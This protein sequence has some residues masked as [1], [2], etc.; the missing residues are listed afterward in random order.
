M[1]GTELNDRNGAVAKSLF[2]NKPLLSDMTFVVEGQSVSC[3]KIVLVT[4]CE[5]LGVMLIRGFAES[6]RQ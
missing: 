4:R 6:S 1:T 2:F 5:V 3:H